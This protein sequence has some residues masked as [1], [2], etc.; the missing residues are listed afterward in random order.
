MHQTWKTRL[1]AKQNLAIES[2]IYGAFSQDKCPFYCTVL[3]VVIRFE[4]S[5]PFTPSG[6]TIHPSTSITKNF[7]EH[8]KTSED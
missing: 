5:I 2:C 3:S 7:Q 4:V 8:L 1:S 6:H